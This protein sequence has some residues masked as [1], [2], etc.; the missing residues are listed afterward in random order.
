[1]E[2]IVDALKEQG[3]DPYA[4]LYGFLR[5]GD[6]VYITRSMGARDLIQQL[7]KEE[8]R[9]FIRRIK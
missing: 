7:D 6:P 2:T 1:M 3:Y 8:I 9:Q 5:N 4:Q